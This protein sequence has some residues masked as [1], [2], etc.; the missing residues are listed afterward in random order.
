MLQPALTSWPSRCKEMELE[1]LN[2]FRD[3]ILKDRDDLMHSVAGIN[4]EIHATMEDRPIEFNER[5]EEEA[6]LH[7]LSSLD[8]RQKKELSEIEE[9]LARFQSGT[10]GICYQCGNNIPEDRLTALPYTTFCKICARK[11]ASA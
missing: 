7:L 4:Q 9:S 1:R 11:Q 5:G 8:Y 2:F 3:M 6:A 10:Y